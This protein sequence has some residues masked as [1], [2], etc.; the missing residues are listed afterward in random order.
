MSTLSLINV[1]VADN[2]FSEMDQ[3]AIQLINMNAPAIIKNSIVWND[4]T[5][6]IY[7]PDSTLM[8]SYS[9]VR[10]ALAVGPGNLS[11]DPL[12]GASGYFDDNGSPGAPEDDVWIPGQYTLKSQAGR[13]D[14][15]LQEWVYDAVTSN[16]IDAADPADSVGAEP[17][18]N[19]QRRNMGYEGGL[20]IASKSPICAMPIPG[21]SNDDCRV[22]MDDL[23][24]TAANWLQ[25]NLIPQ[26]L[27][28][29]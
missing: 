17:E 26:S 28:W 9:N 7:S 20:T 1:T 8:I 13:W 5:E 10:G 25:C 4:A 29:E 2:G 14:L 27:C 11:E 16:C 15:D 6:Q 23:A 3:P 18:P 22:D 19:G 12:F 24:D 21:D